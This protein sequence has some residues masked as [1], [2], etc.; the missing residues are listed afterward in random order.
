[1]LP[2]PASAT[3]SP[4]HARRDTEQQLQAGANSVR[5]RNIRQ[6]SREQVV[7]P[8]RRSR[9]AWAWKKTAP[10][11]ASSGTLASALFAERILGG[12]DDARRSGGFRRSSDPLDIGRSPSERRCRK[13]PGWRSAKHRKMSW[14]V[15]RP[16]RRAGRPC[17]KRRP[18]R[19]SGAAPCPRSWYCVD[20]ERGIALARDR[21]AAAT[22]AGGAA[23]VAPAAHVIEVN[24]LTA[25]AGSASYLSDQGRQLGV[26]RAPYRRIAVEIRAAVKQCDP[27][28]GRQ[29]R[30]LIAATGSRGGRIATCRARGLAAAV[31][32]TQRK[33]GGT[34]ISARPARG[35]QKQICRSESSGSGRCR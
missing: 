18:D 14:S 13:A 11:S 8:G 29:A 24:Q 6:Q 10:C 21:R 20:G 17:W 26:L 25:G 12:G 15:S 7:R 5:A 16:Q 32:A 28:S 22:R 4:I 3:K 27:S 9:R 30:G 34:S 31:V 35:Q 23:P 33:S 19:P 1:M 2:G